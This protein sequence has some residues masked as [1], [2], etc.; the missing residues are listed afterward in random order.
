MALLIKDWHDR[1]VGLYTRTVKDK[2]GNIT[3]EETSGGPD[4]VDAFFRAHAR[5]GDKIMKNRR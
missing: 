2:D 5:I 3:T 1:K 4:S